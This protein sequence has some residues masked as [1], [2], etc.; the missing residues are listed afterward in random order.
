MILL[1]II[2]LCIIIFFL[3]KSVFKNE[4]FNPIFFANT[5]WIAILFFSTLFSSIFNLEFSYSGIF[6]LFLLLFSF[7]AGALLFYKKYSLKTEVSA[8]KEI[9]KIN[10]YVYIIIFFS[11]LSLL[12]IYLQFKF[13]NLKLKSVLNL[14]KTAN[15]ISV[16]RYSE[17]PVTSRGGQLLTS[18]I[19][20][21]A[22]FGG[23]I[24]LLAK[25][26][27]L[28]L[29][30]VLPILIS[31]L[32]S[33]ING[34]KLPFFSAVFFWTSSLIS[35]SI[36]KY[37]GL[38][39]LTFKHI[40]YLLIG[41]IAILF[42]FTTTQKFRSGSAD[43]KFNPEHI[44]LSYFSSL[45]AFTIWWE[46]Y[47]FDG[48]TPF[49]YT[50]SGIHN[51]IFHDRK[52]GLFT[53]IVIL[54]KNPVV[55]TNVYTIFRAFIEDYSLPISMIIFFLLG[56]IFSLSYEKTKQGFW[57]YF[58]INSFFITNLLWSIVTILTTY[59]TMI[60]S[61]IVIIVTFIVI[62]IKILF[63]EKYIIKLNLKI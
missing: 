13:L 1:I 45:N 61:W 52:S 38:I 11:I 62:K 4:I 47:H 12:S 29:V 22:F 42:I 46:N 49:K 43:T 31:I 28:K 48:I 15:Y 63:K 60:F 32:Y 16:L 41:A 50:L 34:V 30:S 53:E 40:K 24:F 17:K 44:Y 3:L 27:K 36:Y 6:P 56:Y 26:I 58:I 54:K 18:F 14:Y 2:I 7:S 51:L 19:Y 57:L 5:Y 37:N 9:E 33:F 10:I 59:N 39:K 23:Y 25:K 35:Y 8:N 21:G 20:C 55:Q